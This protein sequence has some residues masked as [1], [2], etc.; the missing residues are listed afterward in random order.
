MEY[1]VEAKTIISLSSC[2]SLFFYLLAILSVLTV[3]PTNS[4]ISSKKVRMPS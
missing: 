1:M 2:S 3:S 4:T